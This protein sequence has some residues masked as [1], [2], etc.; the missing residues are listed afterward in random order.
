MPSLFFLFLV[1]LETLLFTPI[2]S[3]SVITW[4]FIDLYSKPLLILAGTIIICEDL[5]S[6]LRLFD[7]PTSKPKSSKS[8]CNFLHLSDEFTANIIL[9]P[10]YLN[11]FKSSTNVSNFELY[12]GISLELKSITLLTENPFIGFANSEFIIN[13][14]SSNI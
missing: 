13:F 11:L 14:L 2:I 6:V 12:A 3:V 10:L 4:N 1:F 9:Y 7:I 8:F 5:I